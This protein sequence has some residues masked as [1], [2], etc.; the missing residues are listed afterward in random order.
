MV[1]RNLSNQLEEKLLNLSNLSNILPEIEGKA[2]TDLEENREGYDGLSREKER[3]LEIMER[4]EEEEEKEEEKE[5][6]EKEE[7]KGLSDRDGRKEGRDGNRTKKRNG[8]NR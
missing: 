7:E 6:E 4:I 5:E 2:V 8:S 1:D 3:K